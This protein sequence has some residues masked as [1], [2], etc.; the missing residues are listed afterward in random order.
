MGRFVGVSEPSGTHPEEAHAGKTA[1]VL[2]R[3]PRPSASDFFEDSAGQPDPSVL[4][5]KSADF[6]A[7]RKKVEVPNEVK[8]EAVIA[9]T[10]ETSSETSGFPEDST[11][12]EP[13]SHLVSHGQT[14]HVPVHASP[15]PLL[16]PQFKEAPMSALDDTMSRI[17]GAIV[18][19]H[20][21]VT[22]PGQDSQSKRA[23][24]QNMHPPLRQT[25]GRWVPPAIR[26]RDYG[27]SPESQEMFP[28]TVLMR[29][30]T[31]PLEIP[32]HLPTLS[33]PLEVVHKR[34][35]LA[36]NRPPPAARLEILTFEP[37]IHDMKRTWL[38]NDVLFRISASFKHNSKYRVVIP[39]HRGSRPPNSAKLNVGGAFGR[40]NI[41]DGVTSWRKPMQPPSPL[42]KLGETVLETGLDTTTR[43]PPPEGK[44][45]DN[46]IAS[47]PK[48]SEALSSKPENTPVRTRQPK[49]PEGSAVAFMRDSRID[50]VEGSPRPLV[51]FIVG[52]ELEDSWCQ[53]STVAE[54]GVTTTSR[55]VH[56]PL[57]TKVEL[58]HEPPKPLSNGSLLPPS[59]T[60]KEQTPAVVDGK[61][62]NDPVV[63]S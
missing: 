45:P 34:Q 54:P 33:R 12:K 52:S 53:T 58:K 19:M 41:A 22:S 48:P 17:K 30:S 39:K 42:L 25:T 18:G 43:S 37:P 5:A 35:L 4:A 3:P 38:L 32:V 10:E 29:P 47:I 62:S 13:L 1:A 7:W 27:D 55:V 23:T 51:N 28:V 61:A 59:G 60:S 49:M 31:P 8:N 50:V 57:V 24:Y 20:T 40:P 11:T 46:V 21:P 9:L 16:R 44:A 6:G 15:R 14:V 36:F 2:T 56:S 63:C 26:V